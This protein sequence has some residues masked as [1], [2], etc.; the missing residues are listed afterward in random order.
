MQVAADG[1]GGGVLKALDNKPGCINMYGL[2]SPATRYGT[3]T[4]TECM[5]DTTSSI[6]N[7]PSPLES[8]C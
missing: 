7:A 8:G 5:D 1:D 3:K 6:E 4:Q 2:S